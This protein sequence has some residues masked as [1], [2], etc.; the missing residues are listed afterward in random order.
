MSTLDVQYKNGLIIPNL[1]SYTSTYNGLCILLKYFL[2]K[3]AIA[4]D[5]STL[6]RNYSALTLC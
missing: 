5:V 1:I 3:Y 6:N 2:K 4:A